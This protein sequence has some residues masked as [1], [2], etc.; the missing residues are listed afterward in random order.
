M[1]NM[2]KEN[3]PFSVVLYQKRISASRT[4]CIVC[5]HAEFS[6]ELCDLTCIGCESDY[7][8]HYPGLDNQKLKKMRSGEAHI[9]E[10]TLLT[11]I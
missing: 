11:L 1:I 10:D 5:F 8:W 2:L 7:F 9:L 3:L 4:G 6:K